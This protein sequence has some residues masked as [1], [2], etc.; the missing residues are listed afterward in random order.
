MKDI[1]P[2]NT[3]HHLHGYQEWYIEGGS[4]WFR[5]LLRNHLRFG[6]IEQNSFSQKAIGDKGTVI[7]FY[8]K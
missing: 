1:R 8:I 6:Y 5:G 4:L 3:K 7:L 2:R